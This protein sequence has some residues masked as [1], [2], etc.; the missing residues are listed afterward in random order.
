MGNETAGEIVSKYIY[1]ITANIKKNISLHFLI[2]VCVFYLSIL[3]FIWLKTH[4]AIQS[5]IF[6]Y[7]WITAPIL[8]GDSVFFMI[9]FFSFDL[10]HCFGVFVCIINRTRQF[11]G[12]CEFRENLVYDSFPNDEYDKT[13]QGALI[14]FNELILSRL[15][16][17]EINLKCTTRNSFRRY[18]E[19][20]SK[21]NFDYHHMPLASYK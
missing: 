7:D 9:L 13:I 18:M 8:D 20:V 11:I 2:C 4:I 21:V 1:I 16:K 17:F 19:I 3:E 10:W 6:R 5:V 15:I 14:R 12:P